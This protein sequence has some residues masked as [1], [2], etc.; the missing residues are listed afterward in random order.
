[1]RRGLTS[2]MVSRSALRV[3]YLETGRGAAA[4]QARD[5][6]FT[7]R[8]RGPLL[9]SQGDRDRAPTVSYYRRLLSA[10]YRRN[11]LTTTVV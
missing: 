9:P 2:A 1:V 4:P 7:V 8:V 3:V 11:S 6:R 5:P 10:C